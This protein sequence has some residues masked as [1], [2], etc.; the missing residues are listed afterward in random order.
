MAG[1][2]ARLWGEPVV[3]RVCVRLWALVAGT[4]PE[5]LGS[6][7]GSELGNAVCIRFEGAD[8][9]AWPT[10]WMVR[11]LR[12]MLAVNPYVSVDVVLEGGPF[13][14]SPTAAALRRAVCQP[15]HYLNRRHLEMDSGIG[16]LF[17][18]TPYRSLHR[19]HDAAYVRTIVTISEREEKLITTL[20]TLHCDWLILVRGTAPRN[21]SSDDDSVRFEQSWPVP[22]VGRTLHLS[23]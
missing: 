4:E 14:S 12:A 5:P 19:S 2:G 10:E 11:F 21:W 20:G 15:W 16:R 17:Y 8:S 18:L 1:F 7:L 13:P 3:S 22:V 9:V 6:S 23:A